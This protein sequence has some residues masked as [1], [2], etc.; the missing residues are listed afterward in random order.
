MQWYRTAFD[1]GLERSRRVEQLGLAAPRLIL[2]QPG[3]LHQQLREYR[4]TG[5]VTTELA[6]L[7][8]LGQ[9]PQSI[10]HLSL[11]RSVEALAARPALQTIPRR[12]RWDRSL[13]Q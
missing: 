7:P 8:L 9:H 13:R 2:G 11:Q 1:L 12:D 3:F 4:R 5:I 6:R 10:T